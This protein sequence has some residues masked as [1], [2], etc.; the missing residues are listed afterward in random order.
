[1]RRAFNSINGQILLIP[2]LA[3]IALIAAGTVSV[4]SIGDVTLSE[5][6]AR[7]RVVTE[8]ALKIVESFEDRAA[9]GEMSD[10]AAQAAVKDVLRAVR[11]DDT[12][13]V[14]AR[15]EDG[16]SQVNGMFRDR[17]GAQ[18]IDNKDAN[19]AYF[20][21][22]MIKTA[23]S[24]GGFSYYLWPKTPNTPP[25]RKATYS[26]LSGRWKWVVGSGVYLD[27]VD[28]AIWRN[29]VSTIVVVGSVA[30]LSF[31]LALWLGRRI[32]RPIV[33]LTGVTHS[34]AD[35]DLFVEIPGLARSDEIGT[36][37]QAIAILKERSAEATRLSA[38]QERLKTAAA[39]ERHMAMHQLAAGFEASVK[40][41]VD[42]M[43]SSA[44]KM[45][46]SANSMTG[47]ASMAH[48]EATSAA[49]AADQS[50]ANVGT[51]AA[52][53]EELSSSI[54]E[55]SRQIAHSSQIA[56]DA[57]T[58]AKSANAAMTALADSARRVGDIVALISGIASQT[59]LL[60]LN[61]TIEAARAGEAGKGF[62]VVASEVKSLATQTAKAT[63]EIQATVAAI[64]SM[65]GTAVSAIEG[66]GETVSRMNEI[67]TVV[68][69]AIEEQGAATREIAGNV[70]QAATGMRQVSSNVAAAHRAVTETDTIAATVLGAAGMLSLEADRLQAEVGTFL[71]GIRAA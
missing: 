56:S 34:I 61:A 25:Q 44:T 53:T 62:A 71:A 50:S 68:A 17:E 42:G 10:E 31:G 66:I 69:A 51:V 2:I 46:T 70:Q 58:E 37:A 20:V 48:G 63:E 11:Y 60:A 9:K 41:V 1:M 30:L 23:Q 40:S 33:S 65:T 12:E 49:V 8:A 14:I 64:Q 13:Y 4:R 26:K 54:V 47:A 35:G 59:N 57:V 21:R 16:V 3:F 7:A 19:G 5:R 6:Q 15:H 39:E 28:A 52:A 36:M 29:T 32:T 18:S 55:I 22:D 67:T 24:G 45:E 38:E 43:A 27:D